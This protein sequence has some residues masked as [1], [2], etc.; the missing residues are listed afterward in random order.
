MNT[1]KYIEATLLELLRAKS[2]DKIKVN[3]IIRVVGTCKGTFYKYYRDKY[4]LLISCFRNN[5]YNELTGK[6]DNWEDFV[7]GCLSAFEKVSGVVVNAFDSRDVNSVR[8]YHEHLITEYLKKELKKHGE[9]TK[10]EAFTVNV[11]AIAYTDI[12]LNW[13][14]GSIKG[15]KEQIISCMKAAMP[16]AIYPKIYE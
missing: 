6:A 7:M 14:N 1:K 16:Q 15:S 4:E 8:Y 12:M 5:Y 3:E 11:C 9:P 13:L 10:T 2:I